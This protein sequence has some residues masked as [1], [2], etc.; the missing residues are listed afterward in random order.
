MRL[1]RRIC[2]CLRLMIV[3]AAVAGWFDS[4]A[5]ANAN[6]LATLTPRQY[7]WE[8]EHEKHKQKALASNFDIVFI[9]DSITERWRYP[10]EG[11]SVWDRK[12]APL[13]AGEFG[14][15]GDGVQSVLRRLQNGELGNLHPKVIVLLI[16][17]NHIQN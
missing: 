4:N 12:L 17:T 13:N 9:G 11:K 1:S 7:S 14:I 15:S 6:S 2:N 5:R 10:A 8:A 3:I 16:G